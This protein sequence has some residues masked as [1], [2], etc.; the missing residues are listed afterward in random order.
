MK[1]RAKNASSQKSR[2]ASSSMLVLEYGLV[3]KEK[4][5]GN[6][7]SQTTIAEARGFIGLILATSEKRNG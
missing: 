2:I 4:R 5:M 7:F 1:N 3:L 6:S